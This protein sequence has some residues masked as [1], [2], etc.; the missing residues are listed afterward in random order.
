MGSPG[1]HEKSAVCSNGQARMMIGLGLQNSLLPMTDWWRCP[2]SRL[3]EQADGR[4]WKS[5]EGEKTFASPA[6]SLRGGERKYSLSSA[7]S[8]L[9]TVTPKPSITQ[10][11]CTLPNGHVSTAVCTQRLEP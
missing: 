10:R 6:Y 11:W 8:G 3:M 4:D 1:S 7:P 5:P 2:V 9:L